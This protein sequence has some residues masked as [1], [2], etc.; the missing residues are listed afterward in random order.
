MNETVIEPAKSEDYNDILELF[1]ELHEVLIECNPKKFWKVEDKERENLF[2]KEIF[3]YCLDTESQHFIDVCKMDG[4]IVGFVDYCL[5]EDS[6]F[7][8]INTWKGIFIGNIVVKKEYRRQGI[9]T[10][11]INY[12]REVKCPE[13]HLTEIGLEMEAKNTN[14]LNFY[15]KLGMVESR[16]K[17]SM[18]SENC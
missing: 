15:K 1:I 9:G 16:I 5:S 8:G 18:S 14:A 4:K 11:L 17:F 12:I 6:P 2:P 3:D 7:P 10:K 13:N